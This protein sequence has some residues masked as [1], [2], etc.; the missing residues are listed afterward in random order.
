MALRTART[1]NRTT[2]ASGRLFWTSHGVQRKKSVGQ[3]PWP[4]LPFGSHRQRRIT[5][6]G[7]TSLRPA[8]EEPFYRQSASS[9]RMYRRGPRTRYPGQ[10][11]SLF[12]G[13]SG[14]G[15]W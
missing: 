7:E 6:G 5:C 10:S 9:R 3:L 8:L 13:E 12:G 2:V 1:E 11:I 15:K 14:N 4:L